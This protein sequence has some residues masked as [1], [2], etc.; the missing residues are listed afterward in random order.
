[1]TPRVGVWMLT[2]STVPAAAAVA[3]PGGGGTAG[4]C[5]GV[6]GGAGHA[7]GAAPCSLLA[8][9]SF[10]G[11]VPRCD[12]DEVTVGSETNFRYHKGAEQACVALD[13]IK[14]KTW[15]GVQRTALSLQLSLRTETD[16]YKH[17][18]MHVIHMHVF[19]L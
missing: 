9:I 3:M 19:W 18:V 13:F 2:S 17:G 11:F 8:A 7:A 10:K 6:A 1:M 15:A 4:A 14:S 16:I 5:A 12:S